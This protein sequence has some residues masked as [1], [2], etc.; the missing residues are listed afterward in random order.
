M[1]CCVAINVV[2]ETTQVHINSVQ[3]FMPANRLMSVSM[4][5]VHCNLMLSTFGNQVT[6]VTTGTIY[7]T[8]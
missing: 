3:L 4:V 1:R 6:A 2:Y 8:M 5:L 7:I